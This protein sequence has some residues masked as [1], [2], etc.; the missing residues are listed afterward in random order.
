MS[1]IKLSIVIPIFGVELYIQDFIDSLFYQL[2]ESVECIFINDGS[3]DKSID[4]LQNNILNFYLE[5]NI[6]VFNQKNQGVSVARNFGLEK[7]RGD[8]VTFLDPDDYVSEDYIK[9]LLRIIDKHS[10]NLDIIHFNAE[11]VGLDKSLVKLNYVDKTNFYQIDS[12]SLVQIFAKNSWQPWLRVFKRDLLVGFK[13]PTGY[14]FED[15]LSFPFIYNLDM[16]IFELNDELVYYRLNSGSLTAKVNESF[17]NSL[18]YGI[19]LYRKYRE[20]ERYREIYIHLLNI[21]YTIKMKQSLNE[22]FG[23]YNLYKNDLYFI[24]ENVIARSFK[25]RFKYSYP[26]IFYLYKKKLGIKK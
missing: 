3:K 7:V 9:S 23:F 24:K 20:V 19:D 21:M 6:F 15:L 18:S 17:M 12:D 26:R 8:F 2:N 5:E 4:I 10:E 13:F 22:F 25:E 1:N 14:I 11:V 16:N